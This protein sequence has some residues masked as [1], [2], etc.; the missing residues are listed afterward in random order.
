VTSP[1][2]LLDRFTKQGVVLWAEGSRLRFRAPKGTM[3]DSM[4][5]EVAAAKD[6]LLD[7]WRERAAQA[8]VSYPATH[9][10]QA[11][12]FLSQSNPGSAAYNVVFSAR[13]RS[14]IDLRAL[15]HSFQALVDRHSS[16]RT[17]FSEESDHLV[18]R[19]TGYN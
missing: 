11:L 6:S 15:H 17:N 1:M 10:Q 8:V 5:A 9:G 13:V 7:A 19:V 3:N 2:E 16:L 14:E 12:W 18:Q 4:R